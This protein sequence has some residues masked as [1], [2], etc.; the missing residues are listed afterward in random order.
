MCFLTL[1]SCPAS[2][3]IKYEVFNRKTAQNQLLIDNSK[4]NFELKSGINLSFTK[5]LESTIFV[6]FSFESEEHLKVFNESEIKIYSLNFGNLEKVT[7]KKST[8]TILYSSNLDNKKEKKKKIDTDTIFVNY[9]KEN[10][11]KLVSNI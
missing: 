8:R 6:E 9:K 1:L 2:R 11:I 7:P 3:F 5:N 4:I 10:I